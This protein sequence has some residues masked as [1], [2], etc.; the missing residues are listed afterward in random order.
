MQYS[1]TLSDDLKS[2]K[3]YKTVLAQGKAARLIGMLGLGDEEAS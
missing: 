2:W 1:L 3:R